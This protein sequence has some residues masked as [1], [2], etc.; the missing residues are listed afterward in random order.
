LKR[1]GKKMGKKKQEKITEP[2]GG[3]G[4]G[5]EK[6]RHKGFFCSARTQVKKKKKT[7]SRESN[8]QRLATMNGAT[9]AQGNNL[10]KT[11]TVG[12]QRGKKK[13]KKR[14]KSATRGINIG[15]LPLGMGGHPFLWHGGGGGKTKSCWGNERSAQIGWE[16][17]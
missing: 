11:T 2:H 12:K 9:G 5:K 13:K 4:G 6:F 14:G 3:T 10:I 17:G 8:R 15:Q 16:E 7:I 1:G